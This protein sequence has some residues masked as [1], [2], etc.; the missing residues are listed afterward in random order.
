M[1]RPVRTSLA[2]LAGIS[3]LVSAC[4][5]DDDANSDTSVASDT[6]EATDSE[7][8]DTAAAADQDPLVVA[9]ASD[10][11]T[12]NYIG[13]I[14]TTA[15]SILGSNVLEGLTRM[16]YTED[17]SLDWVPNLAT[18]WEQVG[19]LQW[20]F[21]LREN[22]KFHDG[23]PFTS[24]D[25]VFT[26][27]KALAPEAERTVLLESLDHVEAVDEHTVDIFTTV[28]N[29]FVPR[30]LYRIGIQPDGWGVDNADEAE[31]TAIGTGPYKLVDFAST[32]DAATLQKNEGYW[33]DNSEIIP[34]VR[35]RIIPETGA[36]VAALEAGEVDAVFGLPPEILATVPKVI[37]ADGVEVELLRINT[38]NPNLSDVDVRVALNQAIDR[39][40][41]ISGVRGGKAEFARGQGVPSN[42][43][44]FNPDLQDYAYD[45]D[46]A[47]AVLEAKGLVGEPLSLMCTTEVF[48]DV[49]KDSCSSIG[50]ML[51]DVG[52]DVEVQML[53]LDD[54]VE[55]GLLA[56]QNELT[57]P[58]LFYI[59]TSTDSLTAGQSIPSWF[60]CDS[61]RNTY[62]DPELE[63]L[64]TAA[65]AETDLDKQ[66]VLWHDVMSYIYD[67]APM[68]WATAPSVS[69][70]TA[71]DVEGVVY[72]L[73]ND[74]DA[75]WFEWR[76]T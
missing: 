48:G 19:D 15:T 70:A 57:P 69:V 23:R 47:R 33:G 38:E 66:E 74:G 72:P 35:F 39:E 76:R 24:A 22:V 7:P 40:A 60:M 53:N 25:V 44:G 11:R 10:I 4:G 73:V 12:L 2:A 14:D 62:C 32:R 36:R 59:Q 75:Y 27:D 56:P 65:T 43:F 63:A 18:E 34:E 71:D 51:S 61:G 31:T 50:Q 6:S 37:D 30:S 13:I 26:M 68:I 20:R 58:D 9:L 46:A 41:L 1:K 45:P 16:A 67:V 28:P 64:I 17:G 5:D 52:W 55:Q 54:W 3:L 8:G 29:P 21:K 49:G 42:A